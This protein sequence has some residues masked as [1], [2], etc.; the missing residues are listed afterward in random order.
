MLPHA[1][2]KPWV[3]WSISLSALVGQLWKILPRE[4]KGQKFAACTHKHNAGLSFGLYMR[5]LFEKKA[6]LSEAKKA[7]TTSKMGEILRNTYLLLLFSQQPFARAFLWWSEKPGQLAFIPPFFFFQS[8]REFSTF[9]AK[10]Y[11][12]ESRERKR[13]VLRPVTT[14][15]QFS[16]IVVSTGLFLS[17]IFCL[18]RS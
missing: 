6:L 13:G 11:E 1:I 12:M 18:R 15:S 10:G 5:P 4:E 9:F 16:S 2:F 8:T 3:F 7:V 14:F 17:S